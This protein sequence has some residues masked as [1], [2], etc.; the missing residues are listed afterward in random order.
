MLW[1]MLAWHALPQKGDPIERWRKAANP[2]WDAPSKMNPAVPRD[3][4]ELVLKALRKEPSDRFT[5]ARA[6]GEVLR[7]ARLRHAPHVTEKD[8]GD[9]LSKVFHKEKTGEDAVLEEAVY[10][11]E[12]GPR[13]ADLTRRVAI[14]PPTAL[15]FEHTAVLAP[16]SMMPDDEVTDP[17]RPLAS[18][19]LDDEGTPTPQKDPRHDA[20]IIF[21]ETRI[22]KGTRTGFGVE[23]A[24]A[25]EPSLG[26]PE[27]V[28]EIEAT[29]SGQEQLD[30][31]EHAGSAGVLPRFALFGGI[32]LVALS[33]GFIAVWFAMR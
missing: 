6:F 27:L 30:S 15:A 1:E 2:S 25:V 13:Q 9:L 19:T 23:F 16:A 20:P 11:R 14:V 17:G 7:H 8:L 32:F 33:V 29:F 12:S 28:S 10:G 24:D 31:D 5:S 26:E 18:Q 3:V 21:A 22:V 4:D